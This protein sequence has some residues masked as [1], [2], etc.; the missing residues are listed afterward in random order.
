MK[1]KMNN[2]NSRKQVDES[3]ALKVSTT[4]IISERE[5]SK[6]SRKCLH[7]GTDNWTGAYRLCKHCLELFMDGKLIVGENGRIVKST[8]RKRC[9]AFH[10]VGVNQ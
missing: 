3:F 9:C 10:I 2:I 4:P 6:K 7:C 5:S 8:D 1:I